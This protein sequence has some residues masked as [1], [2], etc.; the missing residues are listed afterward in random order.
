MYS[1]NYG[2]VPVVRKVGGLADT[3]HDNHEF[4]G[5][6]NGFSFVDFSPYALYTSIVRALELYA[7]KPAWRAIQ[8]RGMKS[9]FSWHHSAEMYVRA[10]EHALRK[11][12]GQ[13]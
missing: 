7:D 2:T 6:G 10:Y 4:D 8:R 5:Q 13:Y 3:V 9:D 12:R 1:L 11:R